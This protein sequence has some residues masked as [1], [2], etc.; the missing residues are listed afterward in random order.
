MIDPRLEHRG[1]RSA[2]VDLGVR[3]VRRH[4][5]AEPPRAF[6]HALEPFARE[7]GAGR[8]VRVVDP[9][10]GRAPP[11]LVGHRSGIEPPAVAGRKRRQM[12]MRTGEARARFVD[13][14]GRRRDHDGVP[15][16]VAPGDGERE[17]EDCLLGPV[18]GQD[19]GL[20]IEPHAESAVEPARACRAQLGQPRHSR[21]ARDRRHRSPQ[22]FADEIGRLLARIADAE[23]DRPH[24]CRQERI[25]DARELQERV[26]AT[27]QQ[28][29]VHRRL[30]REAAGR[31]RARP[32]IVA[33]GGHAPSRTEESKLRR[34]AFRLTLPPA[35]GSSPA[36]RRP[37]A[38]SRAGSTRPPG[39]PAP[40][41]RDRS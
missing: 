21:I 20:G 23:V 38:G 37:E 34:A 39:A 1:R 29:G 11:D 26:L 35:T 18:R 41:L 2:E 25:L 22:C 32:S 4:P 10:E 27:A 24:S 6:V 19:L 30:A 14:I 40:E 15:R 16:G 13:R 31:R 28:Q 36:A 9:Q 5:E 17:Q 33:P 7:R 12:H 3:L 8:V